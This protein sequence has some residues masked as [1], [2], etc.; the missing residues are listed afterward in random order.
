MS[1]RLI[2]LLPLVFILS[3][4]G[5]THATEG[6]LG[7]YYEWSGSPPTEPWGDPVLERLDPMVNF[8]W[9]GNSPDPSVTADAFAVRWTGEVVIPSSGSYTFYTQTDDGVRLW[10]NNVL[11]VDN[12]TDHGST[13]DNGVIELTG[14]RRYPIKL[15]YYE[16]GGDAVC[17][18]MWTGPGISQAPIPSTNLWVGGDRPAPYAPDPADGAILRNT[19]ATLTWAPGDYAASHSVYVGENADDVEAG[20]GD[21]FQGNQ[22]DASFALG[23]PGFP[24]PDGLTLGT[25]Y[26]WRI[27]EVRADGVTTD[28]GPVWSFSVAPNTAYSPV[29]S[30]GSG[31]VDPNVVLSWQPGVGA[32]LHTVYF[33]EDYDT[34]SNAAAGI[35]Q[36]AKTYK[37]GTLPLGKVFYWRVDEFLGTSTVKGEVWSFSTP[38]AVGDERPANGAVN[39]KD[40]QIL[41]WSPADNAASHRVYLGTDKDAVR[42]AGTGSPEYKG[43]KS[44]GDESYDPGTLQR[45]ATYY[46]RIDAV[47]SAGT[48]QKGLVWTFTTAD[49]LVV[50]DFE[51]YT[52]D[53]AA[54]EAI[55]QVWID[56]FGVTTNGSQVGYLMPPYA[57]QTVVHGGKQSMPM[58]YDN[59]PG[60]ATYSE[61]ERALS[62]PTNWTQGGVDTLTVWFHGNIVNDA[63]PT[64]VVLNG[65]AVVTNDDPS[66]T[67][68]HAWTRWNIPLQTFADLGVNLSNVS[69]IAIGVG[70]KSGAATAATGTIYVDDIGLH[71]GN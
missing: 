15:E 6:L 13:L 63:A 36:G 22:T 48:V 8:N 69:A 55:W 19:W 24:Y 17:I 34:V 4:V 38:G 46:W 59:A 12:W 54:G 1:R 32:I 60:A 26:Y 2:Y 45:D 14:G 66:A 18:L 37:P 30:D 7:Q 49:Y 31:S 25:T 51:D 42:N 71:A 11:L 56:G 64:Y 62:Y 35:P 58:L 5:V 43:N 39:V 67:T 65:N 29:P 10:V 41:K 3:L 53:D 68:I 70:N 28:N 27:E 9:G 33:G 57:E 21:T 16:N 52:D 44:L 20:T 40:Y 61:A 50:D 47:D 23:F